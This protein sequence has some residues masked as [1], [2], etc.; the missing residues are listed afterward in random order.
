[1]RTGKGRDL[2]A[3]GGK[4]HGEVQRDTIERVLQEKT[5]AAGWLHT[6]PVLPFAAMTACN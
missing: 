5:H 6:P 3:M 1:M 2:L 4:G